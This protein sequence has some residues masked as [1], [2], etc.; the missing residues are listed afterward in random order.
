MT[1]LDVR[2]GPNEIL[3]FTNQIAWLLGSSQ[4]FEP[5]L[6]RRL[7]NRP[8]RKFGQFNL[9]LACQ[10]LRQMFDDHAKITG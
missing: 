6:Q 4:F 5:G 2:R 10:V 8:D 9:R 3:Q 1:Y 7:G